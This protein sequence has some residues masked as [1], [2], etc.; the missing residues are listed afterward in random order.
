MILVVDPSHPLPS[1]EQVREQIVRMIV[2]GTLA[3]GTRLPTI[4]QLANDLGL[5][6]GTIERAY[7]QLEAESMIETRGRHGTFVRDELPVSGVDVDAA[8]AAIAETAAIG[9]RQLGADRHELD[10]AIRRAWSRF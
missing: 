3:A 7:E 1:Y 8:L 9:A 10:A 2:S 4:R 5:A 6:K